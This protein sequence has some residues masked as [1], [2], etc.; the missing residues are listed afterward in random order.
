MCSAP[1][2][3]YAQMMIDLQ[4]AVESTLIAKI[5]SKYPTTAP[6]RQQPI[7]NCLAWGSSYTTFDSSGVCVGSQPIKRASSV[8]ADSVGTGNGST[9]TFS[10]TLS[11]PTVLGFS[12]QI[13]VSD[14]PVA[15]DLRNATLYGQ[16]ACGTINYSTG[17]LNITFTAGHAPASGEAITATYVANGWGIGAGFLDEDDRPAHTWMGTDWIAMSNADVTTVADLNVFMKPS[18]QNT[19]PTVRPGFMPCT[20]TF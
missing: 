7:R 12:L 5:A 6:G 13:L 9:L 8:S 3:F 4:P 20:R 2:V 10:T 19:F 16:N 17:A 1:G 14:R 11:P 15:G 18:P